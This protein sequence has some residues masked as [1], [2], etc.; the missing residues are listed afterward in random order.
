MGQEA[1]TLQ[2]K[3]PVASAFIFSVVK[4]TINLI[5]VFQGEV[6]ERLGGDDFDFKLLIKLIIQKSTT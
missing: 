3:S 1:F 4:W 6:R 2:A 5:A